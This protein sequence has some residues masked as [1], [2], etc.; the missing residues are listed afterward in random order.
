MSEPLATY[1]RLY[2]TLRDLGF[3]ETVN[4]DGP[5]RYF[6]HT[7]SGAFLP[8]VNHP[9]DRALLEKDLIA[10]RYQLDMW[11]VIDQDD[12]MRKLLNEKSV[13]RTESSV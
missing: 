11:G 12:F 9:A 7:E 3:N 6:E 10:T 4:P 13:R 8:Y 5:H 2:E 1:G